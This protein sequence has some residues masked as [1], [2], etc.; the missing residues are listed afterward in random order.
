[1]AKTDEIDKVAVDVA[2]AAEQYAGYASPEK[3][4]TLQRA[5]AAVGN[6]LNVQIRAVTKGL[7]LETDPAVLIGIMEPL[8]ATTKKLAIRPVA[9]P[10]AL[11]CLETAHKSAMLLEMSELSEAPKSFEEIRGEWV[12]ALK[13][14]SRSN[15]KWAKLKTTVPSSLV[16]FARTQL[17][18]SILSIPDPKVNQP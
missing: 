11:I 6:I 10:S 2:T 12:K 1:M 7:P 15:R 3:Q 5:V 8:L 18:L 14:L 13:E 16:Q 9:Y 17:E 4:H